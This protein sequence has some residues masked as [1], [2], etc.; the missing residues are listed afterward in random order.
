MRLKQVPL[1]G[2]RL[3]HQHAQNHT[4]D[5]HYQKNRQGHEEQYFRDA[6]RVRRDVG[7]TE[8]AGDQGYDEKYQ[9][10]LDHGWIPQVSVMLANI[11]GI[12]AASFAS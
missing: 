6:P 12:P 3:K 7:E 4:K 8:K 1:A 10:P 11:K 9:S 2:R 5:E